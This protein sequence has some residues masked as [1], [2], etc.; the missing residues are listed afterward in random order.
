MRSEKE[1]MEMQEAENEEMYRDDIP[2]NAKP[3]L[4]YDEMADECHFTGEIARVYSVVV[5]RPLREA[6]ERTD[7]MNRAE[8]WKAYETAENGVL[9]GE[10]CR[11]V[12]VAIPIDEN[13]EICGQM[14]KLASIDECEVREVMVATV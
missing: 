1:E 9:E 14:A 4:N 2:E 11:A 12:L 10:L 7:Y 8:A 6:S 13:F 5:Y 3:E